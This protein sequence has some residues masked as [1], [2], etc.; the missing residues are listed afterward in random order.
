MSMLI[1]GY[2]QTTYK[3]LI[4]N[5]I[6]NQIECKLATVGITQKPHGCGLRNILNHFFNLD[7]YTKHG[8]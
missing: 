1:T 4:I 7:L 6:N 8:I 5:M 2:G 3:E